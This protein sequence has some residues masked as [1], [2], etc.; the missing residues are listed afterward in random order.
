MWCNCCGCHDVH[1]VCPSFILL[2]PFMN[3][4]YRITNYLLMC[5][6]LNLC[7][8]LVFGVRVARLEKYYVIGS[9]FLGIA[10]PLVPAIKG[11]F[12]Y[13]FLSGQNCIPDMI[14]SWD[15][16]LSI[17]WITSSSKNDR[18]ITLLFS[19]YFWQIL[20]CVLTLLFVVLVS[21]LKSNRSV[22]YIIHFFLDHHDRISSTDTL[23]PVHGSRI[24]WFLS[25]HSD[26]TCFWYRVS[27]SKEALKC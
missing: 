26:P 7:L 20:S 4:I 24:T 9:F 1:W 25:Q 21:D 14:I 16:L 8:V 6:A 3:I 22:R 18:I 15:P 19:L 10:V 13:V 27:L 17:C 5:V 2:K 23:Y 12:G 11:S